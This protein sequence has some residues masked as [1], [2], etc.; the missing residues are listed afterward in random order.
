MESAG[1]GATPWCPQS[2][3]HHGARL[4]SLRS[5]S[6]L[7]WT[8]RLSS[9]FLANSSLYVSLIDLDLLLNFKSLCL[10]PTYTQTTNSTMFLKAVPQH[11]HAWPKKEILRSSFGFLF[12]PSVLRFGC[13][14][15]GH[16]AEAY[17]IFLPSDSRSVP[18]VLKQRCT[19]RGGVSTVVALQTLLVMD[20]HQSEQQL[21][22][23]TPFKAPFT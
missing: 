14:N 12:G 7:P 19:T 18:L 11:C 3:I 16:L 23:W 4:C 13:S 5:S 21:C 10:K 15:K 17:V 8:I 20:I 22:V 6:W 2:D 9:R 1:G